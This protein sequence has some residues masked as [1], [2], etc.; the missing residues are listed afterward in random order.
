MSENIEIEDQQEIQAEV[1]DEK[2]VVDESVDDDTVTPTRYEITSFGADFDVAGLVKRLGKGDIFIPSFQRGY[3]W[4]LPEAS[5][6][7]ESILLG[8]PVPGVFLARE[9]DTN[10]LLVIDG[11]QRLKTLQFFC[12]GVF[13]PRD[14]DHSQR[15]FKL[16]KVAKRFEGLTYK[17]L[18]DPDRIQL[19]D[20]ILHATVV[21]QE[22]PTP[23]DTSIYHVFERLNTGGQKLKP[24]EIREAVYHGNLMDLID[25]LNLD[26]NWRS[27]YGKPSPRLKDSE[28]VLRFLAFY[29]T[30]AKYQR[31]LSEFLNQFA[32][33]NR[34]PTKDFLSECEG[35]FKE[36]IAIVFQT[37]GDNAFK[38]EGSL[39]A[40]VFDSVMV[41]VARR[42]AGGPI[43]DLHALRVVYEQLFNNELYRACIGRGTADKENVAV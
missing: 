14:T 21:K 12:D 41:G 9:A 19:D 13:N 17:S 40:A 35:K 23:D 29:Y 38:P 20:Y 18:S 37:L 5:R 8:L 43:K 33:N 7:I 10:K 25:A 32:L 11:Q 1:E 6:F 26:S 31:P 36:T 3:V 16:S 34:N 2:K 4:K 30:A 24:Q 15:A 22:S 27:I 39:N 42:L 28:L